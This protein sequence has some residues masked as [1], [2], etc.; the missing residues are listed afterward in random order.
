MRKDSFTKPGVICQFS[1]LPTVNSAN[2]AMVKCIEQRRCSP[3]HRHQGMIM[4]R[5]EKTETEIIKARPVYTVP[6]ATQ[7]IMTLL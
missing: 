7:T 3:Q 1:A 5:K 6:A 2:V 4:N